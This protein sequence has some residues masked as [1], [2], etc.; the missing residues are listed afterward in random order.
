M[1]GGNFGGGQ[2]ITLDANTEMSFELAPGSY[3]AL[4]STPA[5]GGFTAGRDFTVIAGEVIL[6]WIIPEN[7]QVFMQFPGQAPQQINN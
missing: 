3:R 5:R 4:W 7:G 6:S 1:S 2:Q